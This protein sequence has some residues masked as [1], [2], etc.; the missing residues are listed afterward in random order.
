MSVPLPDDATWSAYE[1]AYNREAYAH[2]CREFNTQ[3]HTDWRRKGLPNYGL[4]NAT[5]DGRV[6]SDGWFYPSHVFGWTGTNI[7]NLR[8][9]LKMSSGWYQD[10]F[11]DPTGNTI[12]V[13]YI[14]QDPD[15]A[16]TTFIPD[17]S[18]GFTQAGVVRLD[19]SIRTY[20]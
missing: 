19:D 13:D 2:I 10:S 8:H 14:E 16:W 5:T 17:T 12:H 4:G 20:V 18:Q 7:Y 3:P 15:P 11:T 9:D 6:L 1:N